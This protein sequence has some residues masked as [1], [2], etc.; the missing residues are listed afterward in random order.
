MPSKYE[1]DF[2]RAVMIRGLPRAPGPVGT[3]P[4][5]LARRLQRKVAGTYYVMAVPQVLRE[6]ELVLALRKRTRQNFFQG[7][8]ADARR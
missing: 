3:P 7:S 4:I 1:R 5:H 6:G 8:A 2:V